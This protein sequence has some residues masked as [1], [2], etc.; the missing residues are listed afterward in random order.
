MRSQSQSVRLEFTQHGRQ[1]LGSPAHTLDPECST[2]SSLNVDGRTANGSIVPDVMLI[3]GELRPTSG[4]TW[5]RVDFWEHGGGS[6][7]Q[8]S[9]RYRILMWLGFGDSQWSDESVAASGISQQDHMR[10]T[11]K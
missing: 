7:A 10:N 3:N 4:Q 9:S 2:G 11:E 6:R 1:R 8:W 5:R